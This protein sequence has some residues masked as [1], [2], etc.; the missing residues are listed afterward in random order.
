MQEETLRIL[1]PMC[2]KE[3]KMH[4]NGR[5][6]TITPTVRMN[7]SLTV[8]SELDSLSKMERSQKNWGNELSPQKERQA[9]RTVCKRA[10]AEDSVQDMITNRRQRL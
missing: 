9:R 5:A 4:K 6:M 10:L 2:P 1:A 8:V 7:S 3:T